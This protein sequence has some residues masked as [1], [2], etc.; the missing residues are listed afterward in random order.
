MNKIIVT[1]AA[2]FI[3][4]NL[5][6]KL[7][8]DK[9]NKVYGI[10]NSD[11]DTFI[12]DAL[13]H[14]N[15]LMGW[16]NMQSIQDCSKDFRVDRI[17]HL[18]AVADIKASLTDTTM[19]FDNN[20]FGTHCVLEF[21]RERKVKEIVFPSSAVVYGATDVRPTPES[22]PNITPISQYGASKFAC[23]AFIN[24]YS[25]LY[26]I[27]SWIFRFSNVVGDNIHRGVIY[28]FYHKL[29]R[30]NKNLE[31]LGNGNQMKTLFHIS[32]CIDAL[33]NIPNSGETGTYNLGNTDYIT[34]NAIADI[35]CEELGFKPKRTYTGGV[36]GWKG[37]TP[38]CILDI[39]K[40]LSTGWKP[41][42]DCEDAVR[43][44]V[45]YLNKE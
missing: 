24:A 15:F 13:Q 18:A 10:D 22:L 38:H 20:A 37:D 16:E 14:K 42:Y 4:S 8:L 23:E 12:K 17:Y 30:D 21:M 3:G 2:G 43:K 6:K 9:N 36:G 39:S 26:D 31:I 40:V 25:H 44:T 45:Q 11:D 41:Q 33:I 5:V 28:D 27:K 32:D 29:Q 35:V 7:L 34:V 19:D 1:G